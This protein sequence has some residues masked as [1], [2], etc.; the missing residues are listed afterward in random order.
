MTTHAYRGMSLEA[1]LDLAHG[2][3]QARGAAMVR[4]YHLAARYRGGHQGSYLVALDRSMQPPDYHGA[5]AGHLVVFD[6]KETKD[7]VAWSLDARYSHQY[8][9][10]R[11]WSGFGV[12]AFFAVHCLPRDTLYILRVVPDSPW[13]CLSFETPD[14]RLVL[15]IPSNGDGWFDWLPAVQE[16]GWLDG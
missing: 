6:A 13:P 3:Y 7:G 4:H 9:R 5:V 15:V 14:R 16:R 12:L 1:M 11:D 10:L 2:I 8:E